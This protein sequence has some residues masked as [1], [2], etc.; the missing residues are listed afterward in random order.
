MPEHSSYA[1][2]GSGAVITDRDDLIDYLADKNI[3]TSVH[4]KPL[5]KYGILRATNYRDYPVADSVWKSLISLPC[6]PA[7]TDEDID[8]VIY[9]VN[10]YFEDR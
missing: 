1:P 6:H 4:F 8:Y 9:W 5:H 3:H 2:D 10:K 7:M